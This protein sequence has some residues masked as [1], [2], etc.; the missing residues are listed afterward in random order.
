[1]KKQAIVAVTM[2][3]GLWATPSQAYEVWMGTHKMSSELAT[4]PTSWA[5]TAAW[6]DG[7]N[8]NIAPSGTNVATRDQRKEV[9]SRINHVGNDVLYGVAR[10]AITGNS[11]R[12]ATREEIATSIQNM[13]NTAKRDGAT[14]KK[15]MLYDERGSDGVLHAWSDTEIQIYR[16]EL[17]AQG[18]QNA[19]MIWRATNNN[20]VNLQRA[21]LPIIDGLLIEGSADRFINNR[22]NVN[23]LAESFWNRSVNRDKELILQIPRSENSDS[24]YQA[25]R[26]AVL[27]MQ[28]VIGVD[29]V[30]SDRLVILPVTY[31]DNPKQ[32]PETTNN[33]TRYPNTM[34]GIQLS[35]IEQRPYFEGRMGDLPANFAAS[36]DAYPD[37][38][39]H[40]LRS[41]RLA[42]A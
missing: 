23:T 3:L 4:E 41:R 28:N 18:Q 7:F 38:G 36:T 34:P 10:S 8:F 9:I 42:A 30:R 27:E 35:L 21:S 13:R 25:T 37:G 39:C 6:V 17:D 15:F 5:R 33:G 40:R 14:L 29:G 31:N 20:I 32:V 16:E 1:M 11:V 19:K 22:F 2:F 26:E 24:Q 12:E